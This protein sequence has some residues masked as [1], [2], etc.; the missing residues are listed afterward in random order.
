MTSQFQQQAYY[1]GVNS[2]SGIAASSHKNYQM[3]SQHQ[4]QMT[5]P[6]LIYP[7]GVTAS[8]YGPQ[9]M[10]SELQAQEVVL[11]QAQQQVS[12]LQAQWMA[13]Q[14]QVQQ[15]ESHP[16]A[17]QQ[18][19]QPQ[20]QQQLC[21]LRAQEIA[22]LQAQQQVSQLQAQRMELQLQ[23]QQMISQLQAQ[24]RA[25]QLQAQHLGS[26]SGLAHPTNITHQSQQMASQPQP[27]PQQRVSYS[28][29]KNYSGNATSAHGLRMTSQHQQ[30][31][32]RRIS[33]YPPGLPAP[34]HELQQ[35]GSQPQSHQ[36][37]F[38]SVLTPPRGR[39]PSSHAPHEAAFQA[40]RSQAPPTSIYPQGAYTSNSYPRELHF[41]A[42]YPY[43]FTAPWYGKHCNPPWP[44]PS[45]QV[46]RSQP[47]KAELYD[48]FIAAEQRVAL[49]EQAHYADM[50]RRR[51]QTAVNEGASQ[52]S[53]ISEPAY[54]QRPAG[55][56]M[57]DRRQ[58]ERKRADVLLNY[59]NLEGDSAR[60]AEF[61]QIMRRTFPAQYSQTPNPECPNAHIVASNPETQQLVS[62]FET[63]ASNLFLYKDGYD[64][65]QARPPSPVEHASTG[66]ASVAQSS[67]GHDSTDSSTDQFYTP[68]GSIGRP[69]SRFST[70]WDTCGESDCE[71][72]TIRVDPNT[73][74]ASITQ[75]SHATRG[76]SELQHS[77]ET[78]TYAATP[79]D[80]PSPTPISSDDSQPES[81]SKMQTDERVPST[82]ESG[83]F[84]PDT[85]G[86]SGIENNTEIITQARATTD[87]SRTL[88]ATESI[89]TVGATAMPTP[90]QLTSPNREPVTRTTWASMV[91]RSFGRDKTLQGSSRTPLHLPQLQ[92][93]NPTPA[94]ASWLAPTP[95]GSR[96]PRSRRQR[97]L[98]QGPAAEQT[99]EQTTEVSHSRIGGQSGRVR[100]SSRGSSRGRQNTGHPEQDSS[101][102]IF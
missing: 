21:Q 23:A 32:T 42:F 83:L 15:M 78:S 24:R 34:F 97:R 63:V 45:A 90:N 8:A 67:N 68:H 82:E 89:E 65:F 47:T 62:M 9:Q 74:L 84:D 77:T 1:P 66:Q 33:L 51:Q 54:P 4:Q 102:P 11:L 70:V 22:L 48:H 3:T 30:Q 5:D 72:S 6:T 18:V 19:S 94:A 31:I 92:P 73:G 64:N 40:Q 59:P 20:A 91:V 58:R 29:L 10:L 81:P 69:P 13:L 43:G 60:R 57:N 27:Q 14:L 101:D 44:T 71:E 7:P 61:Q 39:A 79:S 46:N 35:M 26:H 80:V 76:D 95:Q 37:T 85:T 36:Q 12:Q 28:G 75:D 38:D 100:G 52:V 56:E 16:Q 49:R 99:G 41:S 96:T 98:F 25:S 93:A 86:Q 55:A 88:G 87:T 17:Q 2:S 50:A 53:E